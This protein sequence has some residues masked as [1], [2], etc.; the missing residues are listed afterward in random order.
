M[1]DTTTLITPYYFLGLP[2]DLQLQRRC[3]SVRVD[4]TNLVWRERYENMHTIILSATKKGRTTDYIL[5][6]TEPFIV[7]RRT[8]SLQEITTKTFF[9]R[10]KITLLKKQYVPLL[11]FLV[12]PTILTIIYQNQLR[13]RPPAY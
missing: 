3:S 10:Q 7:V 5:F 2:G 12:L 6:S 8:S 13:A 9:S 11:S 1:C 4:T